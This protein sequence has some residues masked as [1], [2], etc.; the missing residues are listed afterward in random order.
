MYGLPV[1]RMMFT[2]YFECKIGC[3]KGDTLDSQRIALA[4]KV[5]LYLRT[6][7]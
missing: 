1:Y 6:V 7:R 3:D 2:G 5:I 4:H